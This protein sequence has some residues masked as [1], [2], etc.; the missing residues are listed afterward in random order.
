[1]R[2]S[3][4]TAMLLAA[5]SGCG[6]EDRMP[7]GLSL[8]ATVGAA[9]PL[10]AKACA[11]TDESRH[12][13]ANAAPARDEQIQINC[14]EIDYAGGRRKA[15]FMFNDGSLAFVWVLIDSA[16]MPMAKEFLEKRFGSVDRQI[17]G[18]QIYRSGT[19]ALRRKP[20]EILIATP[21]MLKEITALDEK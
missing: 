13:G 3:K 18:Y 1:M 9:R 21:Q 16:D 4:L 14:Y 15:E 19:A 2:F 6:V 10:I 5:V 8:G 20:P 17:A 12:T 11:R 7:A